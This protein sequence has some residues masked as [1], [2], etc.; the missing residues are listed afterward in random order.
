MLSNTYV[1]K[2]I[3]CTC[4]FKSSQSILVV[5]QLLKYLFTQSTVTCLSIQLLELHQ[6]SLHVTVWSGFASSFLCSSFK[7]KT[8]RSE[9]GWGLFPQTMYFLIKN[10]LTYCVKKLLLNQVNFV[11]KLEEESQDPV[12]HL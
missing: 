4:T 10:S 6:T 5:F 7:S 11:F 1:S 9:R 3:Y 8:E 12:V 2:Q